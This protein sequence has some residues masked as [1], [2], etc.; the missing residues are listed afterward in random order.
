MGQHKEGAKNV[1]VNRCNDLSFFVSTYNTQMNNVNHDIFLNE[2]YLID[3]LNENVSVF[4][5]SLFL[6]ALDNCIFHSI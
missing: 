3:K 1:E 2:F 5:D 4:L 6:H